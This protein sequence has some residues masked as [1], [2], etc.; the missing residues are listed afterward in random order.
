MKKNA[1]DSDQPFVY[2]FD[3]LFPIGLI[4]DYSR[5]TLEIKMV[6]KIFM[7]YAYK[8][9]QEAPVGYKPSVA[10]LKL[11]SYN[12][13]KINNENLNLNSR[14]NYFDL[15]TTFI[16]EKGSTKY[17]DY[18]ELVGRLIEYYELI[19]D[20]K[21]SEEEA[22][23]HLKE[24]TFERKKYFE[25]VDE[26]KKRGTKLRLLIIKSKVPEGIETKIKNE[27]GETLYVDIYAVPRINEEGQFIGLQN[28]IPE[29]N[30]RREIAEKEK[31]ITDE[32]RAK[33]IHLKLN[34]MSSH[35]AKNILNGLYQTV[36]SRKFKMKFLAPL[37]ILLL[38]FN[39][40]WETVTSK[41]FL[42]GNFENRRITEI[43]TQNCV[44]KPLKTF[45]KSVLFHAIITKHKSIPLLEK[46][47]YDYFMEV[48][49][50]HL[51]KTIGENI[52]EKV[53]DEMLNV[54]T[55]WNYECLEEEESAWEKIK[56]LQIKDESKINFSLLIKKKSDSQLIEKYW[57]YMVFHSFLELFL[58]HI[59]HS[60]EK[61]IFCYTN[62]KRLIFSNHDLTFEKG[63]I[64]I[65]GKKKAIY[66]EPVR[67]VKLDEKHGI[68]ILEDAFKQLNITYKLYE[69][70]DDESSIFIQSLTPSN[71]NSILRY[72]K[73]V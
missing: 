51:E 52:N 14:I 1:F 63:K 4:S 73:K 33:T 61:P 35:A 66:P 47:A 17:R 56:L 2:Y 16:L 34:R 40:D 38:S 50:G 43:N 42:K 25:I 7:N 26:G 19:M 44:K 23:K 24:K 3:K 29:V 11:I 65:V 37:Q 30:E 27:K 8:S 54:S 13:D 15:I 60:S 12:P 57:Y 31:K 10:A 68:I 20:H 53:I 6:N 62:K 69:S 41:Y 9:Y 72:D 70:K 5:G 22:Y 48:C 39:K 59:K 32:S 55:I 18:K 28:V 67:G 71:R 46:N 58:N 36:E 21:K 49:S 64:F 45:L